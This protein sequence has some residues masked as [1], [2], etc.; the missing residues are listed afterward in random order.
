MYMSLL[1]LLNQQQQQQQLQLQQQQEMQQMCA[2][3]PAVPVLAETPVLESSSADA[4]AEAVPQQLPPA[5]E[6]QRR[7]EAMRSEV[8]DIDSM[9]ATDPIFCASFALEAHD[10]MRA[11][12]HELALAADYLERHAAPAAERAAGK[13]EA[14]AGTRAPVTNA[15]SRALLVNWMMEICHKF[16]LVSETLYL[17]VNLMDRYLSVCACPR[18]E[19]QLL[20]VTALFVAAKFE[21][22]SPPVLDDFAYIS[23]DRY[24]TQQIIDFERDLLRA[25]EWRLTAPCPLLFLR[26]YSKAAGCDAALHTVG[27]YLL[28]RA[29]LSSTMLRYPPSLQAAAAV[30]LAHVLLNRCEP[31]WTAPLQY[32]SAYAESEV[33]P[34]ALELCALLGDN[35]PKLRFVYQKY[36]GNRRGTV[37]YI[38]AT[39]HADATQRISALR[40]A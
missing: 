25:V 22:V 37:A 35:D 21:E 20:A 6:A 28:E 13:P 32:H 11:R 5:Q 40:L 27:K 33:V 19:L 4:A 24:T 30:Y 38:C 34:C 3:T 31:Q 8:V 39:E 2:G 29:L 18:D 26:R 23:A 17:S 12:E 16:R 36:G 7:R 10:I 9:D 15:R 14:S 1:T